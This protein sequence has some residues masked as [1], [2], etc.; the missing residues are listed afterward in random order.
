VYDGHAKDCGS[1]YESASAEWL[2]GE[3]SVTSI[4]PDK[5]CD[6]CG[7][8][9]VPPTIAFDVIVPARADYVC[10]RCRRP[11]R[12]VGDPP[13]LTTLSPVTHQRDTAADK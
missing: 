4:S 13:R 12:W 5:R 2:Q 9:L 1:L 3:A 7:G 10:L 11:Y 8:L 6:G